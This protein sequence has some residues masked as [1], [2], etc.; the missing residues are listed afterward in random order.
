MVLLGKDRLSL[1]LAPIYYPDTLVNLDTCLGICSI[2]SEESYVHDMYVLLF[3]LVSNAAIFFS[4][5]SE[6]Y[7]CLRGRDREGLMRDAQIAHHTTNLYMIYW[8]RKKEEKTVVSSPQ[9]SRDPPSGWTS[10]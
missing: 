6:R 8:C 4:R 10:S 9:S 2:A 3:W 7:C 1:G 5:V